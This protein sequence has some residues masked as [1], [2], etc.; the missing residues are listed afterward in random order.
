[1]V[2]GGRRKAGGGEMGVA[3]RSL[4]SKDAGHTKHI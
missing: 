3:F 4:V 2:E 1:M